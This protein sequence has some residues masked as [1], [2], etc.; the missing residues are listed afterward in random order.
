MKI[1]GKMEWVIF[2]ILGLP[3]D[4]PAVK[5]LLNLYDSYNC[6][7]PSAICQVEN[8][9]LANVSEDGLCSAEERTKE[10]T[11]EVLARGDADEMR[12][13]QCTRARCASYGNFVCCNVSYRYRCCGGSC[14]SRRFLR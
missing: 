6:N 5:Q 4:I 9:D 1:D 3:L 12:K 8:C 11:L 14:G 2:R 10:H 13:F 7:M